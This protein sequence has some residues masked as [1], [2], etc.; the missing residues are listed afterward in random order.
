[1]R[2]GGTGRVIYSTGGVSRITTGRGLRRELA[3]LFRDGRYDIVHVHGGLAPT[4][5]S[6][7][8]SAAWAAGIPVVATFHSWFA[9]SLAC[10]VFRRPL[11]RILDRHAATIAVSQPVV[12][13]NSRYFRADWEIIPN[14]VDLEF[15]RPN[16]RAPTDALIAGPRLLFLGRHDARPDRGSRAA[17]GD[18]GGGAGE[19]G[20]VLVAPHRAAR[21]RG[22]RASARHP[23]EPAALRR[24]G[25]DL[26]DRDSGLL[27]HSAV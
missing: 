19:G 20:A 8:P 27:T 5:G 16:G 24:H 13:A 26:R 9:R 12:D 1:V 6:A 23:A 14:G 15:F 17:P 21:A 10:R 18:G 7:A 2:R 3:A 11:Q 22:V 4:F 25:A